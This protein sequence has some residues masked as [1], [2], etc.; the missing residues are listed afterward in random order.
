MRIQVVSTTGINTDGLQV[1]KYN[2]ALS[3]G[4]NTMSPVTSP[5]M[6]TAKDVI[7]WFNN[8]KEHK[9]SFIK[10][11]CVCIYSHIIA[12]QDTVINGYCAIKGEVISTDEAFGWN[13]I[14]GKWVPWS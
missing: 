11:G 1:C 12:N 7:D 2:S 13:Y 8:N 4:Y 3:H 6:A 14:D 9:Q 10:Y 5:M